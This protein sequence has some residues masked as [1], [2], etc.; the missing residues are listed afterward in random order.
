MFYTQV[1]DTYILRFEDGEIFPDRLA[2]FVS[3][4][5]VTGGHFTAIGA[6][7]RARI[8]FFDVGAK[9][10]RDREINEQT[11]VLALVGNV[12]M[13]AGERIVHAHITLGRADYSVLGGHL[14][15]GV[16]RPTLEL[17]LAV[18]STGSAEDDAALRRKIDPQF[19]LPALDLDKRF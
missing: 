19:G 5:G 16:V 6:M 10:Y 1:G 7:Q 17:V 4:K 11:E 8:A 13:H 14:R 12:A 15:H 2:E 9:E 18:T 3:S